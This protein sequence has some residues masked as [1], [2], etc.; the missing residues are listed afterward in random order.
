MLRFLCCCFTRDGHSGE[1][2]PLLQPAPCNVSADA[3]AAS[4]RQTRP[5]HSDAQ[6]V[7]RIGKL[8]MRRV[9]VPE[10][11][12][13]FSD[14]AETFN[15]QQER[16][17]AMVQHIRNLQQSCDCTQKDTLSFAECVEKIRAK[18]KA[19]YK[20]SLM[21]KGYDFSLS[22][23]PISSEG[24]SNEQPLPPHLQFA[25]DAVRGTS[26]NAKA[27]VSKGTT[28]QELIGWLLRSQDQ[29]AKQVNGA[30]ESYQE[31]GRLAENLEET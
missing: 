22:V 5:T 25:Q 29:M 1:R 21:I 24:K 4:A 16:H 7:K 17:E 18:Q 6:D 13:R 30:A 31:Q 15:E 2:Q 14:V 20:V 23:L 28:M 12:R 19:T 10:L 11:D 27:T 9:N 3:G 8:V 26:E